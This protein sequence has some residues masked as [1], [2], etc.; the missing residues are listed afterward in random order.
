MSDNIA[1]KKIAKGAGVAFTGRVTNI[2]LQYL[3]QIALSWSLGANFL[4]LYSL[5]IVIYK[6][7]ELVSRMGLE[8][9]A[10]R[11]ISIYYG[12]GNISKIKGVLLQTIG[13]SFLNGLL[14][15]SALFI[16]SN[17]IA[18]RIFGKPE[19][20]A[21]IR[22]LSIAL[23]FGASMTVGAFATVGFQ[24][25]IYKSYVLDLIV[26][27]TNLVLAVLLC[28]VGL[29]VGG[30]A[31]AW[32]IALVLGLAATIHLIR[33]LFPAIARSSVKPTFEGREL[34]TFSLALVIGN[35]LWLVML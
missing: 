4:G 23:P 34:F 6:L 14:I 20:A 31:T 24:I 18:D 12:A 7:G 3:T 25:I 21:V 27:L 13:L 10:T 28:T 8:Y 2:G 19:L 15:G 16:T 17:S 35:F 11:Y 33:R 32:M 5:G 29:E 9:G 22:I 26:P 30:A 1:V